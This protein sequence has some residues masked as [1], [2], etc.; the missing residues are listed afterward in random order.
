MFVV[1]YSST[2]NDDLLRDWQE[3][4]STATEILG[5]GT[6]SPARAKVSLA[7]KISENAVAIEVDHV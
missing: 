7:G 6:G 3:I 1:F 4:K 2:T 5:P